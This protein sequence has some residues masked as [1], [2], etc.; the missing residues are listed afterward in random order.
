MFYTVI[1]S[2]KH[3]MLLKVFFLQLEI[4]YVSIIEHAISSRSKNFFHF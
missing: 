1:I 4:L 2:I 3:K